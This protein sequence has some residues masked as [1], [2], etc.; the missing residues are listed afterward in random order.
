MRT[1]RW[2]VIILVIVAVAIWIDL[3]NN[4]G[5]HIGGIN[6]DIDT[7]LGLEPTFQKVLLLRLRKC[8]RRPEL[9]KIG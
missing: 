7:R 5:I 8:V 4:P 2:L 3:P 1:Y 9:L 6:R